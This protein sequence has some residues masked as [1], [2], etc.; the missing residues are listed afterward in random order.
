MGCPFFLQEIFPTQGSNLGLLHCKQILYLLSHWGSSRNQPWIFI[1]RTGAEAET[2]ILWPPDAKSQLTGKYPDAGKDWGQEEKR[3]T[4]DKM[5]GWHD[6]LDGHEFE[7]T[8]GDVEGQGSLACCIPW[9]CKELDT[10][11]RLN[12]K[13]VSNL[14]THIDNCSRS[15]EGCAANLLLALPDS[16]WYLYL[17]WTPGH[18]RCC[19][20]QWPRGNLPCIWIYE[21]FPLA[22]DIVWIRK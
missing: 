2:P 16:T 13:G 4:D 17:S 14:H 8:L 1:G 7:Q 11:E 10:T 9:D 5:V 12:N 22:L 18:H 20:V 21:K 6:W 3:M 15:L 19:Y